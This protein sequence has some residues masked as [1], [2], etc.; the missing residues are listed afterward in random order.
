MKIKAKIYG[1]HE[2]IIIDFVS[3]HTH[4]IKAVYVD[5]SGKVDSCYI[6]HVEIIDKDYIPAEY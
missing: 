4:D 1:Y 3:A 2:V 5:E 6:E